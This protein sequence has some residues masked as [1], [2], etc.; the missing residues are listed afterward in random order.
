MPTFSLYAAFIA[1][2]YCYGVCDNDRSADPG[3]WYSLRHE[4]RA[5]PVCSCE[6]GH[7]GCDR[8]GGM[9][10]VV[11]EP[12]TIVRYDFAR[13]ADRDAAIEAAKDTGDG[14]DWT[15]VLD[16]LAVSAVDI[17]EW[18]PDEDDESYRRCPCCRVYRVDDGDG[19]RACPDCQDTIGYQEFRDALVGCDRFDPWGFVQSWRF[20]LAGEAHN[21]GILSAELSAAHYRPG[22]SA[23]RVDPD[24]QEEVTAAMMTDDAIVKGWRL[25]TRYAD[26]VERA[27]RSY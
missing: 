9:G 16:R 24:S 15:N 17:L 21:R 5:C 8:C 1:D 20:A 27:G 18:S 14:Y 4:E 11:G 13:E 22:L 6:E 26:M 25:L 12:F 2:D 19:W 10:V 7:E 3:Y 23:G